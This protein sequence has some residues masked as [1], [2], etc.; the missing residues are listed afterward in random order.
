MNCLL[1]EGHTD[2]VLALE[3]NNSGDA[4]VTG[5]KVTVCCYQYWKLSALTGSNIQCIVRLEK[6]AGPDGL[7]NQFRPSDCR[8]KGNNARVYCNI[9]VWLYPTSQVANEK[10]CIL[11]W[12]PAI[13]SHWPNMAMISFSLGQIWVL[14]LGSTCTRKIRTMARPN[15]PDMPPNPTNK[16][17][18]G[19]KTCSLYRVKLEQSAGLM[20]RLIQ[21]Y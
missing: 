11:S 21:Q 18:L 8:L 17:Q 14:V 6:T 1:L 9:E 16:V 12:Y 5:S 7:L 4:L 2:I 15:S 10:P 13:S 20:G 19:I 3:I